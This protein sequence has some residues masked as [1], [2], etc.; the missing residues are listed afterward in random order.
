MSVEAV[1]EAARLL[2]FNASS[3]GVDRLPPLLLLGR[4]RL[5]ALTRC[6]AAASAAFCATAATGLESTWCEGAIIAPEHLDKL[7]SSI[8]PEVAKTVEGLRNLQ[9]D[10]ALKEHGGYTL[11]LPDGRGGG[12]RV[13]ATA[14]TYNAVMAAANAGLGEGVFASHH[15]KRRVDRLPPLL[16]LGRARLLAL[17]RCAAAAS[18]AFCATAATGL[19]ST[20]CE[21]AIIAPEHLDKLRSSIVPEV[22]KTVEGLRNLQLDHALKEHGGY[23]L[24]LPDGRGGGGRVLAT[25]TAYNAVMAAANAGLG[26]GVFASH[27]AKRRVNIWYEELPDGSKVKHTEGG[28]SVKVNIWYEEL[29]DGSKARLAYK[30]KGCSE[31][32]ELWATTHRLKGGGGPFICMQ[33]KKLVQVALDFHL[34]STSGVQHMTK[35]RLLG[36]S[37]A[38][39]KHFEEFGG[40]GSV[41]GSGGSS[42]SSGVS[43]SSSGG[44]PSHAEHCCELTEDGHHDAECHVGDGGGGGG[45]GGGTGSGGGSGG[46][47]GSSIGGSSSSSGGGS[48]GDAAGMLLVEMQQLNEAPEQRQRDAHTQRQRQLL[49]FMQQQQQQRLSVGSSGMSPASMALAAAAPAPAAAAASPAL[50]PPAPP[51]EAAVAKPAAAQQA[52]TDI[53]RRAEALQHYIARFARLRELRNDM[54]REGLTDAHYEVVYVEAQLRSV[55]LK[56]CERS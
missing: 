13:L 25:A 16:L 21:G 51:M 53:A 19:E 11:S 28:A 30:F 3:A 34:C 37:R 49:D 44:S 50:L 1:A 10:H 33:K 18:A 36:M 52:N 2:R 24:S 29:P 46:G 45:S 43:G 15:A 7:R 40:G 23:T 8:V 31:D 32:L 41:S 56:I 5:L 14:T 20:W 39:E 35:P 47:S 55:R 9:L 54:A 6:A 17:T 42:S 27:H 22:A 38:S 48:G 26:E 12:G 4:A